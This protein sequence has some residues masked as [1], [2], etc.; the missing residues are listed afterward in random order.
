M[1]LA[2]QHQQQGK[3]PGGER[4]RHIR[5]EADL[6]HLEIGGDNLD[7][8]LNLGSYEKDFGDASR[9][10]ELL[11]KACQLKPTPYLERMVD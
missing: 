1:P 2:A 7:A 11:K 8:L 9:G 3:C 10:R 5:F 4:G 6:P